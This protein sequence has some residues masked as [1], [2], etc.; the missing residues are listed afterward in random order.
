MGDEEILRALHEIRDLLREQAAAQQAARARQEEALEVQ[1]RGLRR[2]RPFLLG[3]AL[4]ILIVLAF[5]VALLARLSAR[6][7]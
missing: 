5:A 4:A 6:Y 7:W 1:R 3:G 2:V